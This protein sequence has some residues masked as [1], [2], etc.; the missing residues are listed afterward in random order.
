MLFNEFVKVKSTYTIVFICL[1]YTVLKFVLSGTGGGPEA[2]P[3]ND[4]QLKILDI[5]GSD[6]PTISGETTG[7]DSL[8][9]ET[10]NASSVNVDINEL[11]YTE[12]ERCKSVPVSSISKRP[13]SN[14]P[15]NNIQSKRFKLNDREKIAQEALDLTR[16]QYNEQL[17]FMTE[18]TDLA[19][20]A[21][22]HL[23]YKTLK[24]QLEIQ[25]LL[26][27]NSGLQPCL[28]NFD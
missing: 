9:L 22:E 10:V 28:I 14:E 16:Q 15:G 20:T 25:K 5:L 4:E 26:N 3:L 18:L 24:V 17:K 8:R 11:V 6:N 13:A 21:K 1:L 7:I 23:K 27:E 2:S 12:D 19:S